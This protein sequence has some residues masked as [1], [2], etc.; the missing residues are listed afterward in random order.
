MTTFTQRLTRHLNRLIRHLFGLGEH[1]LIDLFHRPNGHRAGVAW[2]ILVAMLHIAAGSHDT[3]SL[4]G[5][6][7]LKPKWE[8]VHLMETALAGLVWIGHLLDD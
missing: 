2:G 1:R 5:I 6:L 4:L 8:I 7:N 3:M